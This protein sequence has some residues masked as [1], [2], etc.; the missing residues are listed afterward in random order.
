MVGEIKLSGS[1]TQDDPTSLRG[2]VDLVTA[3][4][5]IVGWLIDVKAPDKR[6]RLE[7]FVGERLIAGCE[8]V[9]F[10]DD[11][12]FSD[13]PEMSPG[14]RFP[15]TSLLRLFEI[16][17]AERPARLTVRVANTGFVLGSSRPLNMDFVLGLAEQIAESRPEQAH[18]NPHDFLLSLQ[19]RR[20][21]AS[22]LLSRPFRP[23]AGDG[24][25][26][27]ELLCPVATDL[28]FIVGWLRSK[29]PIDFAG[30]IVA[31]QKF[32]AGIRGFLYPRPDLPG[33]ATGFAALIRTTWRPASEATFTV[34]WG[35]ERPNFIQSNKDWRMIS[36]GEAERWLE[37]LTVKVAG[38]ELGGI[39]RTLA[40]QNS[41]DPSD[42][43]QARLALHHGIDRMLV[44]PGFGVFVQGWLLSPLKRVR[45]LALRLGEQVM[46]SDPRCFSVVSRPDLSVPYPALADA[47]PTAGFNAVFRGNAEPGDRPLLKLQF[48]DGS[49]LVLPVNPGVIRT[50][51]R[52]GQLASL[53][54]LCPSLPHEPFFDEFTLAYGQTVRAVAREVRMIATEPCRKGVVVAIPLQSD[55][56]Y[57]ALAS[58]QSEIGVLPRDVGIV[59]VGTSSHPRPQLLARLDDLRRRSGRAISL[60]ETPDPGFI[61]W[62]LGTVLAALGIENFW[63]VAPSL[64][65]TAAGWRAASERF[66]QDRSALE[67]FLTALDAN[68]AE[69]PTSLSFAWNSRD[70]S[71]WIASAPVF[72]GGFFKDNLLPSEPTP[73]RHSGTVAVLQHMQASS[74]IR[75]IDARIFA[76]HRQ[77]S[78]SSGVS[79]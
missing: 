34:Y 65:P 73:A 51:N 66:A 63:F 17:P 74:G 52:S 13:V 3:T 54:A 59:V 9:L 78:L 4:D 11:L 24:V 12:G 36:L 76:E 46:Q 37:E 26:Y 47:T 28:V 64:L 53:M 7:L 69:E 38:P 68:G 5:G 61:L 56:M 15:P 77:R 25:G 2:N 6:H 21:F 8:T 23:Q 16:P 27:L 41:W 79:P 71:A 20:T 55:D 18:L 43:S 40:L 39:Q 31:G 19:D 48:E 67:L 62:S 72:L 35:A 70:F 1:L 58:L 14:F 44:V 29:Q 75:L 45:N 32:P 22:A 57:L 60:I 10:R 33:E 50:C 30:V 49:S 42:S